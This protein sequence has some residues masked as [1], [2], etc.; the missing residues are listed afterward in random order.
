MLGRERNLRADVAVSRDLL[1]RRI[2]LLTESE[3]QEVARVVESLQERR[4][5]SGTLRQLASDPTF[6]LPE[7]GKGEFRIVTPVQGDGAAA[8]QM[9]IADRR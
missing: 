5:A 1:R 7:D 6:R 4:G 9:L 2:D 8:S 3:V